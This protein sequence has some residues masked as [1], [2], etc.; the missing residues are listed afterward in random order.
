[1]AKLRTTRASQNDPEGALLLDACA[2]RAPT[3][4]LG[5]HLHHLQGHDASEL[6][7]TVQSERR[8]PPVPPRGRD[9][10]ASRFHS[11]RLCSKN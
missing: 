5:P 1:M 9:R 2:S 6:H 10:D 8:V 7:P 4:T 3:L 11:C